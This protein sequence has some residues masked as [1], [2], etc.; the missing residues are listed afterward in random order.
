NVLAR[1][2]DGQRV[3][4]DA[5][6]GGSDPDQQDRHYQDDGAGN[7]ERKPP[8]VRHG[9]DALLNVLGGRIAVTHPLVHGMDGLIQP[10]GTR[11]R[12]PG[13]WNAVRLVPAHLTISVALSDTP[14]RSHE[15]THQLRRR[16]RHQG[17]WWGLV[18][19]REFVRETGHGAADTG[20]A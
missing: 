13:A 1:F 14:Q 6:G 4:I 2:P 12:A 8:E 3:L 5:L 18:K 17:A 20:G 11:G 16:A 7:D 19:G 10:G 15:R 9:H